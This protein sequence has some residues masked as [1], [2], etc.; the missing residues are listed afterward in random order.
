MLMG[1]SYPLVAYSGIT[2]DNR[3]VILGNLADREYPQ[4]VIH[5][6]GILICFMN[7]STVWAEIHMLLLI[8][9][10]IHAYCLEK[11]QPFK[12]QKIGDPSDYELR[13]LCKFNIEAEDFI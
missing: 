12:K 1:I 6:P 10:E 3:E 9:G 5:L 11:H 7:A 13:S 2:P 8:D 4:L